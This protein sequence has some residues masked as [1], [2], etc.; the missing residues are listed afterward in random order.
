M[1]SYACRSDCRASDEKAALPLRKDAMAHVAIASDLNGTIFTI[2]HHGE[3]FRNRHE[4][5]NGT[6]ALLHL[7]L[8]RKIG[9]GWRDVTHLAAVHLGDRVMMAG[10]GAGGTL[11]TSHAP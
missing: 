3:L 5:D 1:R 10:V 7:G 11:V 8:G 4:R 9:T 2:D 6:G